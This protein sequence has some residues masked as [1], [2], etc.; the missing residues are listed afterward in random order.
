MSET[1]AE[2]TRKEAIGL[3]LEQKLTLIHGRQDSRIDTLKDLNWKLGQLLEDKVN[4]P[5][6]VQRLFEL[7]K[8]GT[9]IAIKELESKRKRRELERGKIPRPLSKK[10]LPD[11]LNELRGLY[12]ELARKIETYSEELG[13]VINKLQERLRLKNLEEARDIWLHAKK[14]AIT[15]RELNR[16][17]ESSDLREVN[18]EERRLLSILAGKEEKPVKRKVSRTP[19]PRPAPRPV[20]PPKL[21]AQYGMIGSGAAGVTAGSLVVLFIFGI[22]LMGLLILIPVLAVGIGLIGAGAYTLSKKKRA[23]REELEASGKAHPSPTPTP[24]S[25]AHS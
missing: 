20:E 17:R 14:H 22:N 1:P 19:R 8:I 5:S 9:I 21:G 15:L 7:K 13:P 4:M 25:T 12:S 23:Y 6:D 16:L 10:E 2:I 24:E 18:K 3:T 11:D